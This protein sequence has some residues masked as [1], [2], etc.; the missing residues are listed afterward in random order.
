[1]RFPILLGLLVAGLAPGAP[2]VRAASPFRTNDVIAF[3]GGAA[4]IATEQSA[5]LET[6]LTVAHPGHRLRFRPLA[7]EGDTVFGQPRELNFPGP[8]QL[9]RNTQATITC[10]QFGA[11]ES[12]TA[13]LSP[14]RFK[15]AYARLLDDT[16]TVTP[17]LVLV[18]PPPFEIKPHPL[19]DLAP[20]NETLARLA[21]VT[22]ELAAERGIPVID[23][24]AALPQQPPPGPWTTDGRELTPAGH[25]AV[26]AAWLQQLGLPALA[27]RAASPGFWQLDDLA[28]VRSAVRSKNRLW[29]DYWRP[30]NWAFLHGDRVEQLASRDHRDP[31]TR[32]FP[33]EMEEFP[34][35]I[36][37]AESRIESLAA[38]AR[39][40]P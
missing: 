20:R 9:L 16:A 4:S 30:M 31:K 37:E 17:R 5:A 29:T 22:R 19:P 13:N 12:F 15:E 8:T 18:V 38:Q 21:A 24:F 39:L 33:A 35:L 26:A 32:W 40:S 14:A 34:P 6:L 27:R 36:A 23:L 1:M 3:L 10:L 7:W 25:R 2:P 11:L 28:R